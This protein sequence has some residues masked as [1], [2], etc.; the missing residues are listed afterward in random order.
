MAPEYGSQR[1]ATGKHH[2]S[3]CFQL[4]CVETLRNTGVTV[5]TLHVNMRK[6][7]Q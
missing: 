2:L 5:D 3:H 1:Q 7:E 4:G 6:K